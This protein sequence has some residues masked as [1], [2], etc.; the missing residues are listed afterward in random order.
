MAG[1]SA[2]HGRNKAACKIYQAGARL[3][4]NKKRNKARAERQKLK[5]QVRA[6]SR[7]KANKPVPSKHLARYR[8]RAN[9]TV[10]LLPNCET[11]SGATNYISHHRINGMAEEV[12]TETGRKYRIV[13]I[14][15]AA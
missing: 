6:D 9:G 11:M 10:I 7:I 8:R 4:R 13:D 2:K 14:K 15:E 12:L 3:E 1:K 5:A